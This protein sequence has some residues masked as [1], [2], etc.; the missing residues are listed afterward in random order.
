L[1]ANTRDNGAAHRK[2]ANLRLDEPAL[3][4]KM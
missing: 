2:S 3:T 1:P 4:V